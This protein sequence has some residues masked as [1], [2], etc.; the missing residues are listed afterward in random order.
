M[1]PTTTPS[2]DRQQIA[3]RINFLDLQINKLSKWF[4]SLSFK[5]GSLMLSGTDSQKKQYHELIVWNKELSLPV[6]SMVL[7]IENYCQDL[8]SERVKLVNQLEIPSE[9]PG[10]GDP[11]PIRWKDP[12]HHDT[13]G[14]LD[15]QDPL[16][17]KQ[18]YCRHCNL[19]TG[20]SLC[21]LIPNIP[22]AIIPG[23][24]IWVCDT[25]L[26]PVQFKR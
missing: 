12:D 15:R 26:S 25:C 22:G 2:P 11:G 6:A 4:N 20:Q 23:M 14:N 8:I 7:F 18:A 13:I 3:A 19:I 24:K 16:E 5:S 21:D 1:K 9:D 10:S 17:T